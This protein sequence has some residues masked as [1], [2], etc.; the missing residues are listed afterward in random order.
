MQLFRIPFLVAA[1][2]AVVQGADTDAPSPTR[3]A[4]DDATHVNVPRA[5]YTGTCNMGGRGMC[6]FTWW[7][8]AG[9]IQDSK[10]CDSAHP[11]KKDG[12]WCSFSDTDFTVV[13][14]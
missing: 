3:V 12:N 10:L 7:N 2:A 5:I 11:C 8:G 9:W 13:C 14:Q 6:Y 4:R 1:A